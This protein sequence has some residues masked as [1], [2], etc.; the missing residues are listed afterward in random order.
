VTRRLVGL[1]AALIASLFAASAWA[2]L[3]PSAEHE[4]E[5]FERLPPHRAFVV[6][7]D[8]RVYYWSRV[9]GADPANAV[10]DAL[11]SCAEGHNRSC[12]LYAV[13][14]VVLHGRAWHQVFSP[15]LPDIGRLRP[16]AYWLN[17][18]PHAAAGLMVWSH[19]YKSG[20][21]SSFNAPQGEVTNFTA[22][23]FDLYRFDRPV[24]VDWHRDAADLAA[25]VHIAR[26]MG[27]RRVVLA[28]QSA[29]AW[30]SLAA[31]A[32]GAPVDGVI[33]ISA[34]HHGEVKN[35]R[36]TG[37]ARSE[38]RKLVESIS[39]GPRLVL[40]QFA[41]DTFDVGGRMEVA[42]DA[43]ARSGVQAMIINH[44]A[45]FEG[46]YAGAVPAFPLKFGT[47]IDAYI[48]TGSRQAPC[49]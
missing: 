13:N 49:I 26:G 33:S 36:D 4:F 15:P 17:R 2:Q 27:Y 21:D 40:V 39:P 32:R 41:E 18:G 22:Q 48:Q 3:N 25:A 20:T 47:C 30:V 19:G 28:G 43:F 42:H 29:G 8:G 10:A 23:G 5:R 35:M 34:A 14:N 7:G 9:S 16:E 38:W 44:P 24:I 6:A 1:V 37:F 45:G 11:K 12:S 31:L 46:H